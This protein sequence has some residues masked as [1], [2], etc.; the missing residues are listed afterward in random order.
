MKKCLYLHSQNEGSSFFKAH[1]SSGE[2]VR[3]SSWKQEFDSPM[4]YLLLWPV[5][6]SVR[7]S[8][9]HSGKRGSIPL[10]ATN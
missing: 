2:D 5:R 7:T 6:L 8:D 1:S 9:F 10:R 3:F 4:G